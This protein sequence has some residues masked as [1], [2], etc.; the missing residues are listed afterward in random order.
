MIE[1]EIQAFHGKIASLQSDAQEVVS[2]GCNGKRTLADA[3]AWGLKG[4]LMGP[5]S[6][7]AAAE[8]L[9]CSL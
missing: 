9:T 2:N 7:C 5:D 6:P 3:S 1:S 4:G 8:L